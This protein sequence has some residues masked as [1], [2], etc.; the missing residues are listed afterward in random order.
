MEGILDML[1]QKVITPSEVL[2]WLLGRDF[3]D[4]CFLNNLQDLRDLRLE[5]LPF[6]LNYIRE[7]CS[8]ITQSTSRAGQTPIKT[9]QKSE[10]NRG[11]TH[12]I[13]ENKCSKVVVCNPKLKSDM[14]QIM[15]STKIKQH[16]NK[17]GHLKSQR[18][19][20]FSPVTTCP[21]PTT[22]ANIYCYSTA[23]TGLCNLAINANNSNEQGNQSSQVCKEH[24]VATKHDSRLSQDS[25]KN[26]RK[27]H[28]R[29]LSDTNNF[30]H[31]G[32]NY[33][34]DNKS[35]HL[36][37][38]FNNSNNV[39]FEESLHHN[40]D[41]K[42][43]HNVSGGSISGHHSRRGGRNR[44]R[45]LNVSK[46]DTNPPPNVNDM[47]AFP[48]MGSY[49]SIRNTPR[50]ITAIQLTNQSSTSVTGFTSP[51]C[52]NSTSV[53]QNSSSVFSGTLLKGEQ[54]LGFEKEHQLLRNVQNHCSVNH[55]ESQLELDQNSQ[56]PVKGE[57]KF[58]S[59][60]ST[61]NVSPQQ[62]FLTPRL[63]MVTHREEILVM[64]QLYS[65]CLSENLLPNIT[66]ELHFLFQLLSPRLKQLCNG[67]SE[68]MHGEDLFGTVHNCVFF[69][70]NIL[71]NQIPLLR[72]LDH[73]TLKLLADNPNV[74]NFS[75]KLLSK[76][77]H[78]YQEVS[79]SIKPHVSSIQGVSFQAE[80]D[81]RKNF[82]SD[83][84]FHMFRKQRD[85]FYELLRDWEIHHLTPGW[86]EHEKFRLRVHEIVN[87][88]PNP[89]NYAHLARLIHSQLLTTCFGDVDWKEDDSTEDLLASLKRAFPKKFEKLQERF[90]A[91]SQVGGPCPNPSFPYAQGFFHDF[92]VAAASAPL[93]QHL[94]DQL[95]SKIYE[96][97]RLEIIPADS[98]T[99]VDLEIREQFFTALHTL[100]LL[101]KF[102]GFITFLPYR[103]LDCLP[104]DLLVSQQTM[105]NK[106]SPQINLFTIVEKAYL[107]RRLVLTVPWVVEFLSMMDPVAPKLDSYKSTIS[108]LVCIYRGVVPG[109]MSITFR[110]HLFLRLMIGW[111]FDTPNFPQSQFFTEI[112]DILRDNWK[113]EVG[114]IPSENI[115]NIG[116]ELD[117]FDL[118][119]H[120]II[121]SCCPYLSELKVLLGTFLAGV[122]SKTAEVRK[123]TPISASTSS[124]SGTD[125]HL[126]YQLEEN[127]F[128]IH[129][130][131]MK[132]TVEFVGDRIASKAIKS[133]KKNIIPNEKTSVL[134][135]LRSY[136]LQADTADT[137]KVSTCKKSQ[138][139]E[140]AKQ[141]CEET[142]AK[143]I[144]MC[145]KYCA[146]EAGK[147]V[148]VLLSE[149][150]LELVLVMAQKISTR[151]A[152]DKVMQW[153]KV[154]ITHTYTRSDLKAEYDKLLKSHLSEYAS[155][156]LEEDSSHQCKESLD[157]CSSPV[158]VIN[159]IKD[160]V[161]RLLVGNGCGN[162]DVEVV[163]LIKAVRL[164]FLKWKSLVSSAKKAI[165]VLT[166]DWAV[167]LVTHAPEV[168][169]EEVLD[170]FAQFWIEVP[171][172]TAITNLVCSR[173]LK[174]LCNSKEP[175]KSWKRLEVLLLKLM[176]AG[177]I[178]G[179]Q[180]EENCLKVMKLEWPEIILSYFAPCLRQ[181]V[182]S[183]RKHKG[184]ELE[185][186]YFE[187]MEWL[188]WICEP[189]ETL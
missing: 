37:H 189:L 46:V 154:N 114:L 21:K 181:V 170:M 41:A 65:G 44:E 126:Q 74:Q 49:S 105:R 152:L 177:K 187:L 113:S 186:T 86:T 171:E 123:I 89:A 59:S 45:K 148:Q 88:N 111:L 159:Q 10:Y 63:D 28:L 112:L 146:E 40:V 176:I 33:S 175:K 145:Q 77:L 185:E 22:T 110:N 5:F 13:K 117:C 184:P 82:P 6:F 107:K 109:H 36:L 11:R 83:R 149:D 84:S 70:V 20:K 76:L 100:R 164:T 150:T 32:L 179:K 95:A 75:S 29:S 151:I 144:H 79:P 39:G 121:Y 34:K 25:C 61:K 127:F 1:V 52:T 178:T 180:L 162:S 183:Y 47:E 139:D 99:G 140:L 72:L 26:T 58:L 157:F 174:L 124:L 116:E 85:L 87:L 12:C 120:Q 69:A 67:Q 168:C 137:S 51:L 18:E 24:S 19:L 62:E 48:P 141:F 129:S 142:Q 135:K 166:V 97:N 16:T 60:D 103:T 134:E 23:V 130:A 64:V 158:D 172:C 78:L 108:L 27:M 115:S 147:A 156:N 42:S 163:Q 15:N 101:G 92:L 106:T 50:R 160:A 132:K 125:K 53:I 119:D 128:H 165:I 104:G 9:V 138:I 173:N 118:I 35:L 94:L 131:S 3:K 8:W 30:L 161:K 90:T 71:E 2:T 169:T 14:K 155:S 133:I 4:D 93:N 91:P 96:V 167:T 81:N 7:E 80:T 153:V 17:K 136:N 68:V 54:E 43:Q 56:S 55:L 182:E 31:Q 122:R 38:N 188:A 143:A 57:I 73:A 66:V 98:E 102:M